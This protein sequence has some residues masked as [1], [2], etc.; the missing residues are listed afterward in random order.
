MAG[1][2]DKNYQKYLDFVELYKKAHPDLI[3]S[4]TGSR[5]QLDEANKAWS[6][7]KKKV[8]LELKMPCCD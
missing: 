4:R 8:M 5:A 3:T 1:N 6:V 2:K 7:A